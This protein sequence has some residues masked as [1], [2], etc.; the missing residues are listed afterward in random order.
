MASACRSEV[1][2]DEAMRE[3]AGPIDLTQPTATPAPLDFDD[4]AEDVPTEE[5]FSIELDE[6]GS[7]SF[8]SS[9]SYS[10]T[11]GAIPSGAGSEPI[12]STDWLGSDGDA[13]NHLNGL[14]PA[15]RTLVFDWRTLPVSDDQ[16]MTGPFPTGWEV[17][18]PFLGTTLDP[19]DD[20]EFFTD[21]EVQ[22]GCQ[23][24]CSPQDW[25]AVMD[26]PEV[27]PF[28]VAED[29]RLLV[30]QDLPAIDGLAPAGRLMVVEMADATFG[31]IE[32]TVTRWSDDADHFLWCTVSLEEGDAELWPVFAD[33]CVAMQGDWL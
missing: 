3:A 12:R 1:R 25:G 21:M 5:D 20:F 8:E 7:F 2:L 22:A 14:V 6:D 27:S 24:S 11:G 18:E 9:S 23:G 10:A 16:N 19:G 33:M 13:V 15:G 30:L 26:D 32:I 17:S 4:P 28:G 31:Q 29:H